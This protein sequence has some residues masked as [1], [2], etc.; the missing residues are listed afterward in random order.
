VGG[1]V[2]DA[3]PLDSAATWAPVGRA[4]ARLLVR[5]LSDTTRSA[6]RGTRGRGG[7]RRLPTGVPVSAIVQLDGR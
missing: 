2:D 7:R 6:S 5:R 1:S 4:A 3:G